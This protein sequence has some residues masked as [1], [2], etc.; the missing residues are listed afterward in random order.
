MSGA[1]WSALGTTD[2]GHRV[3]PSA[4]ATYPVTVT[5][6]AGNVTD[7]PDGAYL[8]EPKRHTLEAGQPGDHRPAVARATLDAQD[9]LPGCP[10]LLLLTTDLRKATQAFRDQHK[11]HA[12]R[13]VWLETGHISQN[14]YLWAADNDLGTVLIAG[15]DDARALQVSQSIIPGGHQLLAVLGLGHPTQHKP[16][17]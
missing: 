3:I 10:A 8:Y 7:L 16:D 12:E 13:F 9:W 15:I 17:R 1:L 2:D 5:L 11:E 4:R 14:L 6:I